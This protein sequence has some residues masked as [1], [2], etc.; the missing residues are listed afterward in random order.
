VGRGAGMNEVLM[1]RERTL[2][3]ILVIV[4]FEGKAITYVE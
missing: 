3:F 1:M 4:P 2:L